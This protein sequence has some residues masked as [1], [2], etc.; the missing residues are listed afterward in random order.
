MALARGID[1]SRYQTVTSWKSVA[2]AGYRFALVKATEGTSYTSPT[3]RQY[4]R[5]ARAAGLLT[6]SYHFGRPSSSSAATQA[7]SYVR[8]LRAVGFRSGR[9]LPPNLDIEDAGG[10]S[11]AALTQWCRAFCHEVDR[12]LGLTQPWLRCGFYCNRDYYSHRLD[13]PRLHEGRWWWLAQWPSGQKQPHEDDEMPAGAA[14]WQWTDG[15]DVSG[16]RQNCDLNVAGDA[17]L[18]SL[19]PAFYGEDDMPTFRHF[20]LG[21]AFPIPAAD[22]GKPRPRALEFH[23]EWADPA[24]VS[25]T[26][27]GS[28]YVRR[29]DDGWSSHE[30]SG[31]R[32]EGMKP[33]DNY[34]VQLVIVSPDGDDVVWSA[35]LAEAEATTGAE[36]FSAARTLHTKRGQRVRWRILYLGTEP[37][38]RVARAEWVIK[39]Y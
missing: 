28:S 26:A 38:V 15:G 11:K 9:D 18:R 39:E 6:G 21:E 32:V 31:V 35:V 12:L 10:K 5:D 16:V 33:G 22:D 29:K 30:L 3:F 23:V 19:A 17:E 34:Q 14:I 7:T 37:D 27:G 25:H 36:F 1:V 20:G 2:G 13:G 4:Y 24:P 8:Q